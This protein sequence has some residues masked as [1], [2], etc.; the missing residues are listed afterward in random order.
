MKLV[1]LEYILNCV[2]G[3]DLNPLAVMAARVNYLLAIAD[4]IPHRTGPV[5][6]PVYLADSI[7]TPTE[8]ATLFERSR[9]KLHTVVGDLPVPQ[10]IT[11]VE[12]ISKLTDLLD[13]YIPSQI[14]TDVFC[15]KS[16]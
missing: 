14:G 15:G 12:G 11:S 16:P 6:L 4:L 7:L 1:P 8:G 2:V 9:L 10:S 5:A 13:E 3:V